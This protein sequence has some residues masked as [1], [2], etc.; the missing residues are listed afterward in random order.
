MKK[1]KKRRKR[2]KQM[3]RR[4]QSGVDIENLKH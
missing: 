1:R 2:V 3:K 4:N